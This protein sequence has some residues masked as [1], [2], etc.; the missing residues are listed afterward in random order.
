MRKWFTDL[1]LSHLQISAVDHM[2]SKALAGREQP[3]L[4]RRAVRVSFVKAKVS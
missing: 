1:V 3:L 2:H 4:S